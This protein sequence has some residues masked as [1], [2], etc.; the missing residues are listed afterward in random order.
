MTDVWFRDSWMHLMGNVD[1][2]LADARGN[3]AELGDSSSV[4]ALLEQADEQRAA[5]EAA[6]H[7][8]NRQRQ[9]MLVTLDHVQREL[10]VAGHPLRGEIS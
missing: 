5:A 1:E 4:R 10:A 7:V 2:L 6:L 9:A 8:F 3:A